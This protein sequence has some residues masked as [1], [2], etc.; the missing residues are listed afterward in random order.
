MGEHQH[1]AHAGS[2]PGYFLEMLDLDGVVLADTFSSVT[3]W[4]AGHLGDHRASRILDLGSG[5]GTGTFALL[6]RFTDARV[7]ALDASADML[8][9]LL[10]RAGRA[11]LDGQVVTHQ[12]DLDSSRLPAGPFDLAWASA[13]MHHM[14]DPARVLADLRAALAPGGLFAMVEF[15]TFPRFLPHGFGFG[16]PGLEDRLNAVADRKREEHH[17]TVNSDWTARLTANGFEVREERTF[18]TDLRAPLSEAAQRYAR[19]TLSR[20]REGMGETLSDEDRHTL[21]ALLSEHGP[22]RL[23]TRADLTVRSS[24]RAWI[25]APAG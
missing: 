17:P 15:E 25:A 16:T 1:G 6:R 20:L 19:V 5:T 10:E 3:E 23:E 14:A 21:D 7:T 22:E 4:I 24:R 11:G 13:S 12:A 8:H 2:E 9:Y 18:Q